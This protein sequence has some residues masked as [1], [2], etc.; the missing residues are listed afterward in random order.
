MLIQINTHP[1]L[2]QIE[3]LTQKLF[4]R[5]T[6]TQDAAKDKVREFLTGSN[7]TIVDRVLR[8][9]VT[10]LETKIEMELRHDDEAWFSG[11]STKF[12]TKEAAMKASAQSRI[13]NY[14]QKLKEY[15][16]E[17]VLCV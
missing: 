6:E 17:Q 7:S 16:V 8:D 3:R 13:R 2:L 1:D 14:Y 4:R 15:V 9:Y 12:Q 10:S 11:L 5:L